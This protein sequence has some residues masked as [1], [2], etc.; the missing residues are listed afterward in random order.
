[1][2]NVGVYIAS[3][4]RPGLLHR[5]L[6]SLEKQTMKPSEVS[7]VVNDSVDYLE[8]YKTVFKFFNSSLNLH[9]NIFE[10]KLSPGKAKN[11]AL[12]MLKTTYATG[13]DDDDYYQPDRIYELKKF[14]VKVGYDKVAVFSNQRV[15]KVDEEF[16]N[17]RPSE[18]YLH[19]LSKRNYVGNQVFGL[20]KVLQ[21]V[22]YHDLKVIDDY[23]FVIRLSGEGIKLFNAGGFSYVWDQSHSKARVTNS[24]S[25]IFRDTYIERGALY[26]EN[27]GEDFKK[28]EF[29]RFDYPNATVY[30]ADFLKFNFYRYGFLKILKQKIKSLLCK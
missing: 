24:Y 26:S 21:K 10:N 30:T 16:N 29:G 28:F 2:E 22:G 1:M 27:Y 3:S 12:N 15:V 25:Q 8:E 19:D 5:A 18:V 9:V 23:D 11:I 17:K 7:I 20:T 13:L 14:F 4:K 6:L